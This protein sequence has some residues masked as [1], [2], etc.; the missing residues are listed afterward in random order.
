MESLIVQT[1]IVYKLY[2]INSTE[3]FFR[4]RKKREAEERR[5][6]EEEEEALRQEEMKQQ[7]REQRRLEEHRRK[8]LELQR[9]KWEAEQLREGTYTLT[10]TC[11]YYLCFKF[12]N[13][14]EGF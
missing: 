12:E 2:S 1:R 4:E 5:Q 9:K 13:L 3:T 6:R 7:A 10:P 14:D 8:L 11:K